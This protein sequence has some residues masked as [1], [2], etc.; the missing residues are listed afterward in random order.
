MARIPNPTDQEILEFIYN[1]Y[2]KTFKSYVAGRDRQSKIYVPIDVDLVG[3]QFKVDGDII[4]G[5]LYYHLNKK[6][7]YTNP[8]NTK[9]EFFALSIG[10][11]PADLKAIQ[12][13]LM[14]SV[15]A[16][17]RLENKKYR[18]ATGIAITSLLVS[19]V[20]LIISVAS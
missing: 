5:R 6:Y 16:D 10:S 4:F 11:T 19:L 14:A 15:L 13:P 18:I 1:H 8:D 20:A 12:F 3:R 7:T 2:Y 17:M 9:I